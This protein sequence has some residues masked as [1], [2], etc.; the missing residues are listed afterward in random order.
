MAKKDDD[1]SFVEKVQR[2]D[3]PPPVGPHGQQEAHTWEPGRRNRR[4]EPEAPSSMTGWKSVAIAATAFIAAATAALSRSDEPEPQ[5][6]DTTQEAQNNIIKLDGTM[7]H[8]EGNIPDNTIVKATGIVVIEGN[9]GKNVHLDVDGVV[10]IEGTVGFGLGG[11]VSGDLTAK[12]ATID[13]LAGVEVTGEARAS[14]GT[15]NQHDI[16]GTDVDP[17]ASTHLTAPDVPELAR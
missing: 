11:G 2:G 12:N 8:I 4:T 16:P 14:N 9:V 3:L 10:T 13:Q 1:R 17:A 15:I 5:H 7:N 6:T